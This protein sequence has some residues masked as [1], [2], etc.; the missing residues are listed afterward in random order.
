MTW[1][2]CLVLRLATSMSNLHPQP[3]SAV[4]PPAPFLRRMTWKTNNETQA[5]SRL[6]KSLQSRR[7]G[8]S[9]ASTS[10]DVTSITGCCVLISIFR[11]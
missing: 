5:K 4:T 7:A 8:A 6:A 9:Q 3:E 1:V 11:G 2:I 10:A